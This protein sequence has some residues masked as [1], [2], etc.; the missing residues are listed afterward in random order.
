M[1][2]TLAKLSTAEVVGQFAVALAVTGP[3]IILATLNIRAVQATE[4]RRDFEFGDYLGLRILSMSVACSLIALISIAAGYRLALQVTIG[5]VTFSKVFDALSDTFYGL[6]QKNERMDCVAKSR[7]MQGILQFVFFASLIGLTGSLIWATF[8]MA[9]ASGLT[10][11]LYDIPTGKTILDQDPET[12]GKGSD[13]EKLLP[14]WTRRATSDLVRIAWPLGFASGMWHLNV[15]IPRYFIEH[16]LGD[17][18]VG[19]FTSMSL[20]MMVATQFIMGAIVQAAM[21]RLA[22]LCL[23][24]PEG[25]HSLFRKIVGIGFVGGVG[26]ILVAALWGRAILTILYSPEYG[27]QPLVFVWLMVGTAIFSVALAFEGGL[28]AMR[29]FQSQSLLSVIVAG[30]TAGACGWFVPRHGL[31]GAAWATDLGM[32]VKLLGCGV[33][34]LRATSHSARGVAWARGDSAQEERGQSQDEG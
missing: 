27:D 26:A 7:I 17:R 12:S 3:V 18:E 29:R 2:A 9:L 14:R 6:A 5:F 28:L 20:I 33:V 30:S 1:I 21:P 19:I 8:G 22:T 16:S 34:F 31:L 23:V 32:A 11:V 15:Y 10:T 24:E 4:N 25:F 13:R